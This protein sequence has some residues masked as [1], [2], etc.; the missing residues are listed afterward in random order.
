MTFKWGRL[1]VLHKHTPLPWSRSNH[2]PLSIRETN[3]LPLHEKGVWGQN[4][5]IG[6]VHALSMR[7]GARGKRPP[8]AGSVPRYMKNNFSRSRITPLQM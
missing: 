6:Q 7:E 1:R 8:V 5:S 3:P 4:A 2:T